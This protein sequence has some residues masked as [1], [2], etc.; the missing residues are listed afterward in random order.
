VP[1]RLKRKAAE[2][3]E[4]GALGM[5]ALR[6]GRLAFWIAVTSLAQWLLNVAMIY[7]SLRAFDIQQPV[8]VS[9]VVMGVIAF[10][11]T[12]PS[13]PGFFGV[14]QVAFRLS[15][16]PFGVSATD[17]VAA[18][19]YYQLTQWVTITL[20]GLYFLQRTGLKLGQLER[21]AEETE[22]EAEREL[23][24]MPAEGR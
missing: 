4:A 2:L 17:A 7:A 11:V 18:S 19:V 13:S 21:A 15:L 6:S 20:V 9:A 8:A 14:I 16:V 22:A 1:G 3:L 12:V 10:G 24:G 5:A 23:P